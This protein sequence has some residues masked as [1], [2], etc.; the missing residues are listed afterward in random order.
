MIN[1][2]S[3][4]PTIKNSLFNKIRYQPSEYSFYYTRNYEKFSLYSEEIDGNVS[5]H[6][7]V[8]NDGIWTPDDYNLCFKRKYSLR[9]YQYL[10]G[11]NG[12]ACKN[13]V[14]GL[15]I[16]WTSADSKQRGVIEI[17]EIRNSNDELELELDYEFSKAQLRG[18]V[19][20]TTIVYIK[21]TGI[22]SSNEK[23]LANT[24]GYI[25][26]RFDNYIIKLDGMGSVFPVYETSEPNKPLW[27]IKCEWEDPTDEQFIESVSLYINTA[28]KNYKY[29]DKKKRTFDEQLLKEIMSSAL[30]IIITKIKEQ[31]NFWD[32]TVNGEDLQKGS[33]SEAVNYF[34]NTLGWDVSSLE[35]TSTSIRKFFDQRM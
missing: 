27:Y 34:I 7:I 16:V 11:E 6:K 30:L 18:I 12:V 22:S 2:I 1:D 25:L 31:E 14:L 20:F 28:H 5:I 32:A 26:G 4:F 3:L 15:A 9:T 21:K 17:G 33:V 35:S 23:H 8:D 13:A 19:E 10:F 29:L 24:C